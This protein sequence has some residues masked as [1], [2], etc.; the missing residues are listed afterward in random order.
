MIGSEDI[1]ADYKREILRAIAIKTKNKPV[2]EATG[3]TGDHDFAVGLD[4]DRVSRTNKIR[5]CQNAVA[6]ERQIERTVRVKTSKSQ[7]IIS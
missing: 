1:T 4:C 5:S 3:L 2:K 7:S 6:V